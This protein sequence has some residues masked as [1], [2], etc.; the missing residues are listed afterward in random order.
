M[1][2]TVNYR[3]D[4]SKN[5]EELSEK[6]AQLLLDEISKKD[7]ISVALSGGSTPKTIFQYLAKNYFNKIDWDK[8]KFFWGDERCVSPNDPESNYKMA[9]DNLFSKIGIPQKNIFRIHGEANPDEEAKQY[10]KIILDEVKNINQLPRF[11]LMLLGLGED[12]HTASIFPDQLELFS[13]GNICAVAEHP[14]TEQK[15]ISITGKTINNSS[16]I[17]FLVTGENKKEIVDKIVNRKEG[18][19]NLPASFVNPT[20]GELIWMIDEAA[21]ELII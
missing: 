9:Y 12:G 15:R 10:E 11:D 7:F 13:S 17:I 6:F 1:D 5:V 14:V 4:I 3:I 21:A 19:K 8:I 20:R 2:F 16:K 18:Y